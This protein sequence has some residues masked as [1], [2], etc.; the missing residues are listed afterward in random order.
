MSVP[1]SQGS[2]L[3]GHVGTLTQVLEAGLHRPSVPS[4][5]AE[6][7]GVFLAGNLSR[8][9]PQ[10]RLFPHVR[11]RCSDLR[12]HAGFDSE[13]WLSTPALLSFSLKIFLCFFHNF[14]F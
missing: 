1:I 6:E 12:F 14:L 5:T 13:R 10:P 7:S 4:V 11:F 9:T 3:P 8:M 2:W